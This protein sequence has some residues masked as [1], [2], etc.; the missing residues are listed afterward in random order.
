M[1]KTK[2]LKARKS[3]TLPDI[4]YQKI[5]IS[6]VPRGNESET[7][8]DTSTLWDRSYSIDD[9]IAINLDD[10]RDRLDR[11]RSLAHAETKRLTGLALEDY[12]TLVRYTQLLY[13]TEAYPAYHQEV[14][15]RFGDLKKEE[16]IAGSVAGYF[17]GCLAKTSLDNPSCSIIC[18]GQMPLPQNNQEPFCPSTVVMALKNKGQ[19]EFK[20]I[21]SGKPT[22]DLLIY[23]DSKSGSFTG[24]NQKEK[25]IL[26]EYGAEKIRIYRYEKDG[27][28]YTNITNGSTRLSELPT[29]ADVISNET[30]TSSNNLMIVLLIFLILL[31]LFIGWR[32]WASNE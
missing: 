21:Y 31:I 13:D 23:I 18:A 25:E 9:S 12:R 8:Y 27:K 17:A 7:T 4:N 30:D 10:I 6:Q 22:S 32:I 28:T 16:I 20:T 11:L 5:G 1:S 15:K 24:F 19:Y 14:V 29:R 2:W 3:K 26:K